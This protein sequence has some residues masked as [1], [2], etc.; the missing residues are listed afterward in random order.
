[1]GEPATASAHRGLRFQNL[2]YT[3]KTMLIELGVPE[4]PQDERLGHHPP[5][6]RGV[7]ARTIT[8]MR[9]AMAEGLQALWE[10]L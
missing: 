10:W 1:M 7:Y 3:R 4:I 2:R 5:G 9:R 6:M 8:R